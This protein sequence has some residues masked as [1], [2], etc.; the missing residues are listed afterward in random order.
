METLVENPTTTTAP[1]TTNITQLLS[2]LNTTIFDLSSVNQGINTID[3]DLQNAISYISYPS[4]VSGDLNDLINGISAL[5]DVLSIIELFP[6]A[7]SI[8]SDL[9]KVLTPLKEALTDANQPVAK[10]ADIVKPYK[11]A[12]QD[13]ET[14]VNKIANYVGSTQ[15]ATSN[16][17][18]EFNN[19]YLCVNKLPESAK[20]SSL[21]I[22]E[23][24]SATAVKV[25]EPANTVL[26]DLLSDGGEVVTGL[27]SAGD[28]L[29]NDV[30][31]IGNSINSFTSEIGSLLAFATDLNSALNHKISVPYGIKVTG[32]WY[33]PWNDSV[34]L[35]YFTFTVQEIINGIDDIIEEVEDL[36]MDAVGEFLSPIIDKLKSLF[37]GIESVIL[38]S[39]PGLSDL[40]QYI[41]SFQ[42]EVDQI[43]EPFSDLSTDVSNFVTEFSQFESQV[44][45]AFNKLKTQLDGPCVQ[46]IQGA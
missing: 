41:D 7:S 15:T 29:K 6:D 10:V 43:I 30:A 16:F 28:I 9:K 34:K 45:V 26:G 17:R 32:P 31:P 23:N 14:K 39:V 1:S 18:T 37:S 24:F 8:V 3:Y 44:R 22:L 19:I 20:S 13:L 11:G 2:D 12:M 46:A 35:E 38:K 42:N 5:L 36:L 21:Q 25:V 33:E 27:K 40:S 4:E